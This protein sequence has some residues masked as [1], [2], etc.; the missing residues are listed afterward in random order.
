M[1]LF[2]ALLE[3]KGYLHFY[4]TEYLKV[5]HVSDVLH[6]WAL[7]FALNDIRSDPNRKHPENLRGVNFY[8]TPAVPVMTE[9][10][11]YKRNP[12]PEDTGAGKMGLMEIEYYLPGSVFSLYILSR[13]ELEPP[14]FVLYGKKRTPCRLL[15]AQ[16]VSDWRSCSIPFQAYT[17]IKVRPGHLVNPIDYDEIS[18]VDYAKKVPMKPSPLFFLSGKFTKV[19]VAERIRVVVPNLEECSQWN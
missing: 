7:M 10:R 16:R 6:N 17:N 13:D 12:I 9:R 18:D 8:C 3:T 11:I 2:H 19:L 15:P 1:K 14:H 4:S 5:T